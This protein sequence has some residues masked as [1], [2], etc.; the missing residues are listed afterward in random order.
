MEEKKKATEQSQKAKDVSST[1]IAELD[2]ILGGG[3]PKGAVIL[4]AG[5]SG[6]GKTIFAF[7]WL[8]KGVRN[9]ENGLYITLTEPLFK[10]LKNLEVMDFYDKKAIEDERVKILD[11]REIYEKQG[12]NQKKIIAY[13]EK[14]VQQVN[15][16]RLCIDSITAIAYNLDDKAEI[17]KFIF[18]LG[19]IL[20]TL[21][22]TTILT[23]E[24]A[25]SSKYSMYEV[26]EFISDAILRFDQ[27]NEN[28][29][30]QRALQI[31]KVRGTKYDAE[32]LHFRITDKG[33]IIFPQ[34][35]VPLQYPSSSERISTGALVLD[36]MLMG[37]IFRGSSTLVVGSTGTGKSLLSTQFI[38]DGLRKGERCLYA[39]FEEGRE[40]IIRNAAT[41]EWNLKE[42]EEQGLLTFNCVYPSEKFLE[43]HLQDIKKIVEDKKITRCVVDSLSSISNYFSPQNFISFVKR[44]NGYL[45]SQNIT[46]YFTVATTSLIGGTTL[47]DSNISTMTDNIFMLRYVEMQ[48][49][50]KLVLNIVKMRG[51]A[52]SKGLREYAI[53]NNGFQVGQSLEGYEGIMS[54][55]T[56]KVS[57]TTE[58]K[59]EAE[60]KRVIG[61]MA[62]SVFSELKKKGL[63]KLNLLSYIDELQAK[64]I[65]KEEDA[66][67]F[68]QKIHE[69]LGTSAGDEYEIVNKIFGDIETKKSDIP[70]DK[71]LLKESSVTNTQNIPQTTSQIQKKGLFKRLFNKN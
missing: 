67:S 54:G 44:L 18:D 46:T 68:K 48:G 70:E 21:G 31:V 32:H 39:G 4:L 59:L 51:S 23:S 13:I 33:I 38:V 30:M 22:C 58:E 29:E 27:I 56:K 34:L 62:G 26:E 3:F 37:G 2:E 47:T 49:T 20:A 65:L 36:Q 12:F 60:F 17:R 42:Y 53:T 40:Q 50:L 41:F 57:E 14:Q 6:S 66:V 1:G 9:N 25:D 19:K 8:F 10:T 61:P 15:A 63:T 45:K 43:E 5:S 64:S 69:I 24:V 11:I 55:I 35:K 16:K 52:H 7:Q 28:N 71:T